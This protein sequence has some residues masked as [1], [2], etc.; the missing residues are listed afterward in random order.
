[1]TRSLE[2]PLD[3]FTW[4]AIDDEASHQGVPIDELIAFSVLYY[5]ADVDSGRIARSIS[6]SGYAHLAET[7]NGDSR[8]SVHRAKDHH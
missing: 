5:L 7:S 8:H 4:G 1:M 3:A 6:R 2:L